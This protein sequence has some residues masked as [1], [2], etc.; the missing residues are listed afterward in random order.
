[1]A[2]L[3]VRNVPDPLYDA[4]RATADANGR[5][6]GAQAVAILNEWLA[7]GGR[8]YAM[9]GAFQSFSDEARAAVV[10][11]QAIARELEQDHVGTEH[12]LQA[13][14]S[15]RTGL[16]ARALAGPPHD[17]TTDAVRSRLERG[18]GRPKGAIPFTPNAKKALEL[19]LRESLRQ[20]GRLI[21]PGHLAI[22]VVGAEGRGASILA[23][24][25]VGIDELRVA[26][27]SAFSG[28]SGARPPFRVVEL[29]DDWE[30][31]LNEL[32]DEYELVQVVD[33]RAIFR[34]R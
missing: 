17:V 10:D 11:A 21:E 6:I 24:L 18:P 13:I 7:T 31:Q 2:T 16:V 23:E 22:G 34:R 9:R 15:N 29:A 27:L 28:E 5:P 20:R 1:M 12:L 25:G 30:A 14:L 33:R 8:G 3:H 26:L 32:A 4:L 19:A